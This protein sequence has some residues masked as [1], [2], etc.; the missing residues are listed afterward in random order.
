MKKP[1]SGLLRERTPT[2]SPPSLSPIVLRSRGNPARITSTASIGLAV[3]YNA[4][5]RHL[6]IIE[7][8]AIFAVGGTSR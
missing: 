2:H 6:C 1:R 8:T 4:L 3:T 5:I 7:K